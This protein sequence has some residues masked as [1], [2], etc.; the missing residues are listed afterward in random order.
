M[1]F[2]EGKGAYATCVKLGLCDS[3]INGIVGLSVQGLSLRVRLKPGPL[4][5][6]ASFRIKGIEHCGW[7]D[8]GL[9]CLP[10]R[11]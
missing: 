8:C 3:Q 9:Q 7:S 10:S 6:I 2:L 4:A 11:I 1:G 5:G